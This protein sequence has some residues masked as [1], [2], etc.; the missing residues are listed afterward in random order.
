ME[1]HEWFYD[2]AL[3]AADR[4]GYGFVTQAMARLF[5]Q[6]AHG[7]MSVSELARRLDISR[8]SLHQ[9]VSA[10]C[11]RGLIELIGDPV[12]RRIRIVRFTDAGKRMS[13]AVVAVDLDLERELATHIGA[14]NVAAMKR[15]LL[16]DW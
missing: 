1:R 5:I 9:T 15:I 10:A 2:R 4:H 13:R 8:Q 14:A 11:E 16:M 3:A 7:P 6:V 12:N